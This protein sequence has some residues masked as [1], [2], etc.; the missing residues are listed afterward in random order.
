MVAVAVL[1]ISACAPTGAPVGAPATPAG[2]PATA[3]GTPAGTPAVPELTE[4]VEVTYYVGGITSSAPQEYAGVAEGI[5]ARHKLKLNYVV[6][7]GTSQAVQAVAA[8][9]AGLAF[10]HGSIL[11]EMLIADANPDAP[12]LIS[13][14]AGA[15][16][17]PVGIMFLKSSGIRTPA[18]LRG[19]RIGVPTG[20]LSEKYLN[21][22][23]E[24]QGIAKSE[25]TIQNIG[26]AAQQGALLQKQVDAISAFAR[27]VASLEI[28]APPGDKIG[29]FLFGEFDMPSPLAAMTIQKRLLEKNPAVARAIALAG[30]ESLHFCA[31]NPEKCIQHFVGAN[32]GRDYAQTLAEWQ[33]AMKAQ[34][35]IDSETAKKLR[36]LQLG[37]FDADLIARTVPQLKKLFEIKRDFDPTTLYT[38][39]FVERR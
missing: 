29:S 13:I 12:P 11:D 28:A 38:N 31:V 36:P 4:V 15:M 3:G 24:K 18:D 2:T 1:A 34:F 39:Q 27:A 37:W 22:F 10:T 32:Q 7:A 25:V 8:D 35:G 9:R 23:L 16:L 17:N 20:S 26:F 30:T 14:A 21:V 5:Y 6:L 33:V 19:K